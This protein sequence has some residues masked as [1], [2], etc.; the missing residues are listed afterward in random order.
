M[1]S[2]IHIP[3]SL[4][5]KNAI[6][7]IWQSGGLTPFQN[8][9]II[10]KGIVEVIFNFS[11]GSR[12]LALVGDRQYQL[13]KCFINGFNRV[14]VQIQLPERLMFLGIQIQPLAVRKILGTPAGEFSDMIVDLDLL[15]STFHS[16]WYQ[17]ACQTHFDDRG[18]SFIRLD[19]KKT[20]RLAT[21]G[22]NDQSFPVRL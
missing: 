17:L 3:Q 4:H 22:K 1:N 20:S 2:E 8:E 11:E 13:S 9:H 21:P 16:L 10:P 7:A 15:E 18:V 12:I 14:P 5:L 6:Q 19:R